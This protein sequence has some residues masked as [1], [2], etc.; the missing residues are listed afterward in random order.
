MSESQQ[1]I[2]L[3]SDPDEVAGVANGFRRLI[4]ENLDEPGSA[5]GL[6]TKLDTSR[7]RVN[8]HLRTLEAAG[9]V[10]LVG[11]RQ[12]RGFT[13]R[14]VR[15]SADVVLVDPS[16]FAGVSLTRGDAAGLSGV[17]AAAS[18]TI[19]LAAAVAQQS[20][21]AGERILSAS[22]ETEIRLKNP[23]ALNSLLEALATVLAD[24]NHPQGLAIRVTTSIL[25]KAA[26]E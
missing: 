6:A 24:H 2:S 20:A 21:E 25:P 15:R 19:R 9:L 14:I 3:I 17:V 5:T 7:Q 12:R 8:Y 10:E 11:T 22:L 16:A 18:E 13:E 4:L 26:T 23:A 1:T